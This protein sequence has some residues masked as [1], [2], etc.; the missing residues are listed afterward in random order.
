MTKDNKHIKWQN[1]VKNHQNGKLLPVLDPEI[2][3]YDPVE[4]YQWKMCVQFS[5]RGASTKHLTP[6][7]QD[8]LKSL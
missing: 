3:G 7:I 8:K 4:L 6:N 5:S 2:E 1:G